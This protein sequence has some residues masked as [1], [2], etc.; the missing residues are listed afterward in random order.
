MFAP[1]ELEAG[2]SCNGVAPCFWQLRKCNEIDPSIIME[3]V[4]H[5]DKAPWQDADAT[6]KSEITSSIDGYND[7]WGTK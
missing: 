3:Q 7:L 2:Q 4:H 5:F 6:T 1:G